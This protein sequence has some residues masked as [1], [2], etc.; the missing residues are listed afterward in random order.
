MSKNK[1]SFSG[2]FFKKLVRSRFG[3]GYAMVALLQK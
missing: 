1:R 3:G 2:R